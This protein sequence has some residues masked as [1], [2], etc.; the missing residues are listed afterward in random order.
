MISNGFEFYSHWR[1]TFDAMTTKK[2]VQRSHF[3]TILPHCCTNF[4]GSK[5]LTFSCASSPCSACSI[6][7]A[8]K[9]C[10]IAPR[11]RQ[12]YTGNDLSGIIDFQKIKAFVNVRKVNNVMADYPTS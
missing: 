2:K 7:Q 6:L 3:P 10:T 4:Y 8:Y 9:A 1:K 5:S 12:L 11:R